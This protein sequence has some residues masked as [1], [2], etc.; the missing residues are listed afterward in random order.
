MKIEF[1]DGEKKKLERMK[2]EQK[3]EDFYYLIH[4]K[5]N[6]DTLDKQSVKK[7]GEPYKKEE[8]VNNLASLKNGFVPGDDASRADVPFQPPPELGPAASPQTKI[9]SQPVALKQTLIW[10]NEQRGFLQPVS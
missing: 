2:M 6:T 7:K 10:R 1:I 8:K 4:D 3:F 5:S 9:S